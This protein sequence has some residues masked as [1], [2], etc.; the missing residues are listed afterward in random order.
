MI[1]A[2]IFDFGG[3]IVDISDTGS[4]KEIAAAMG[5]E[6]EAFKQLHGLIVQKMATG[7]IDEEGY[8]QE[9]E[10]L[11]GKTR[12]DNW[13]GLWSDKARK[14]SRLIP[15]MVK[16]VADL[17][18]RGIKCIVLSNA[19]PPHIKIARDNGWYDIFDAVYLSAET[20]FYKPDPRAFLQV[21]ETEK[22]IAEECLF[23]DDN[24]ANLIPATALGMQTILAIK[25]EE[26]IRLIQQ[27]TGLEK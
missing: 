14:N 26:T 2:V 18:A 16:L 22:L 3:V 6:G 19:I 4:T 15:G 21:T 11:T 24:E 20:G 1:K 23:I 13:R 9:V 27:A 8:W 17:K 10:K 7:L 25:P 12:P 5:Q